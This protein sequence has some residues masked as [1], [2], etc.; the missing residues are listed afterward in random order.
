IV[1]DDAEA[2][3]QRVRQERRYLEIEVLWYNGES[4]LGYDRQLIE[5]RYPSGVK[6]LPTPAV[7]G[8]LDLQPFRGTPMQDHVIAGADAGYPGTDFLNY[9]ATLV[10]K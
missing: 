4:V 6:V 5:G 8:R 1:I 9:A 10:A 2:R 3:C 7:N